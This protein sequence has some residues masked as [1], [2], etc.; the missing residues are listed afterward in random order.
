MRALRLAAAACAVST[1]VALL[2]TL[3]AAGM[4]PSAPLLK[5]EHVAG[6]RTAFSGL[7]HL[8]PLAIGSNTASQ[9]LK[10]LRWAERLVAATWEA[11][12]HAALAVQPASVALG[13]HSVSPRPPSLPL[14]RPSGPP[15]RPRPDWSSLP[16]SGI[17]G[18]Y[19][20]LQGD[21]VENA[22]P[23]ARQA[24]GAAAPWRLT[25]AILAGREPI[26]NLL[27]EALASLHL[28]F[29][30]LLWREDGFGVTD[31]AAEAP[32]KL[33]NFA[34][35]DS[36]VVVLMSEPE[37]TTSTTT[38]EATTSTTTTEA[39]T[40]TTTTKATT[41]TTT[42]KATTSTT[43]TATTTTATTST[44]TTTSNDSTHSGKANKN[45]DS[46][47]WLVWAVMVV[48]IMG[49]S[50][51]LGLLAMFLTAERRDAAA[52]RDAPVLGMEMQNTGSYVPPRLS[53]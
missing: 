50:L 7:Q 38:A 25:E 41:S 40:S 44:Q 42:A 43:T 30:R 22:R 23:A 10:G 32:T 9:L 11:P 26:G 27:A 19:A 35:E 39:T 5:E 20:F 34:E 14:L 46:I 4:L 47:S 6:L 21:G 49:T 51:V 36:P 29:R 2:L 37:S 17:A 45:E 15:G 31:A 12:K 16:P 8:R 28:F 33:W 18:L 48:F 53:T 52:V 1:T 13:P 24:K 3:A